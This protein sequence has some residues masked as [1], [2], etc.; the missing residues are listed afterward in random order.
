MAQKRQGG[1]AEKNKS[2]K[3]IERILPAKLTIQR[4]PK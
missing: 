2:C 1:K 4:Q 3:G